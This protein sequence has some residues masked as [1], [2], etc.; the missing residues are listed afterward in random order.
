MN[1]VTWS[2]LEFTLFLCQDNIAKRISCVC[3]FIIDFDVLMFVIP[4]RYICTCSQD[5]WEVL[6]NSTRASGRGF[7]FTLPNNH[8]IDIYVLLYSI[9]S[10]SPTAEEIEE[11]PAPFFADIFPIVRDHS[12]HVYISG[13]MFR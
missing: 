7:H 12:C 9:L 6:F 5:Y 4:H 1:T 8:Q 3:G 2:C 13:V 11:L 10:S